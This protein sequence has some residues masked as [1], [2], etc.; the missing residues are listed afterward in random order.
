MFLIPHKSN[1]HVIQKKRGSNPSY[2]K[3]ILNKD[4]DIEVDVRF[5][6]NKF[7]LEIKKSRY[8]MLIKCGVLVNQKILIIFFK[9]LDEV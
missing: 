5:K 3:E 1:L 9:I 8:T 6:N 2:I 4:Y 7:F